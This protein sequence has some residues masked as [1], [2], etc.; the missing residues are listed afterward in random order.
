MNKEETL[1]KIKA[2]EGQ[3]REAKAA[4]LEEKERIL[5]DARKEGFELREALRGR[6]EKRQE[7]ILKVSE[8][9]IAREKE[10]LLAKGRRE[11]D[12]LRAEAHANVER[13]VDRLIER[14]KGALNA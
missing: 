14:F 3:V 9:S 10:A 8:A 13:A 5:R 4:A 11:A 6:A 12:A 1:Q 7:E 2:A